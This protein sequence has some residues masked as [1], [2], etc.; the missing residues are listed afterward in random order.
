[1]LV[2][3]FNFQFN[4]GKRVV[5]IFM[6]AV[7]L[8]VS[9]VIFFQPKKV[10]A[11][12]FPLV[13]LGTG[14]LG[15]I[16]S[17]YFATAGVQISGSGDVDGNFLGNYIANWA[18]NSSSFPNNGYFDADGS[19]I[20][21]EEQFSIV[22]NNDTDAVSLIFG[23]EFAIWLESLKQLFVSENNLTS[24]SSVILSGDNTISV[25]GDF[26]PIVSI[27]SL[28]PSAGGYYSWSS[29]L[30]LPSSVLPF[31]DGSY[32]F[33]FDAN[34]IAVEVDFVGYNSNPFLRVN[35]VTMP[36]SGSY[37]GGTMEALVNNVTL[38]FFSSGSTVSFGYMFRRYY[39]SYQ[40][41][42][43]Q[44]VPVFSNDSTFYGDA[45]SVI[46]LDGTLTDGYEDFEDAINQ[47]LADE[48]EDLVVGLDVGTYEGLLDPSAILD[49]ILDRIVADDF[50]GEYVGPFENQ[51][52]AEQ[53]QE[54]TRPFV[55]QYPSD[56]VIVNGIQSFFPFCIPWDLAYLI[57]LLQAD[58]VA[59]N[60]KWVLNFGKY[61]R[62]YTINI[63]LSAYD[64]VARV[65]RTMILFVFLFF[66]IR[67][68]RNLIRG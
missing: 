15:A 48:N 43:V 16:V 19:Y 68:T 44:F 59:P 30:P 12:V 49:Q 35:R 46:S 29:S 66:L 7:L 63:D 65:F 52:E 45:V 10:S 1:M 18:K 67:K 22:Q 5:A 28:S 21:S 34:N 41:N 32:S 9:S 2:S 25:N 4:L 50:V 23:K 61:A 64:A 13:A 24:D 60:F 33:E 27:D 57:G 62:P 31:E 3:R 11:S 36:V 42:N 39:G 26:F 53:E 58:P 54:G 14:A 6:V 8:F 37:Y 56:W 47:D 17:A 51:E 38:T 55:P 40:W 20:G